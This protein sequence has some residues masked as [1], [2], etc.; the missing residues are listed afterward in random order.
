MQRV[1]LV[2]SALGRDSVSPDAGVVCGKVAV[3]VEPLPLLGSLTLASPSSVARPEAAVKL[4]G[5]LFVA[6]VP[7]DSAGDRARADIDE[8]DFPEGHMSELVDANHFG[9]FIGFPR[10]PGVT[11]RHREASYR[12]YSPVVCARYSD[13]WTVRRY[14]DSLFPE[15]G[16]RVASCLLMSRLRLA[17][18]VRQFEA[19]VDR[20]RARAVDV[21]HLAETIFLADVAA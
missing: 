21:V 13:A 14:S 16:R 15:C 5:F 6:G 8:T 10:C 2:A 4:E 3:I 20:E 18:L 11:E 12:C 1:C 9:W 17:G 7:S 19:S